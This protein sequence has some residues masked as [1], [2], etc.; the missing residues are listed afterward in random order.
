[1]SREPR[2]KTR[3]Q[4]EEF[5]RRGICPECEHVPCRADCRKRAFDRA[6]S[7]GFHDG[8]NKLWR[9]GHAF[10]VELIECDELDNEV[11]DV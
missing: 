8:M 6:Y 11:A 1:M 3:S 5:E 4:W 10:M 2:Q 7:L 9:H